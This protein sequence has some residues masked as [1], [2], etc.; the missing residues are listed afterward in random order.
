MHTSNPWFGRGGYA[1]QTIGAGIE[2]IATAT[3][4]T[5]A[6]YGFRGGFGFIVALC[7]IVGMDKVLKD[8]LNELKT[9]ENQLQEPDIERSLA[10]AKD[11]LQGLAMLRSFPQGVSIFGSARL[12]EDSKYYQSARKLGG[13][14]ANNGHP[15]V[16][17]GGHGIMAAASF[18]AYEYGGRVLGLNIKLPH[19]QTLNPYV[20]DS[21]EFHYFFARKVMLTMAAKAY[22]FYPGGFGTIDEFMEILVLMQTHKMPQMP[23]FLIDKKFWKPFEKF[24]ITRLESNGLISKK[25]R[26]FYKITDDITEVVEAANKI[27]HQKIGENI[28]DSDIYDNLKRVKK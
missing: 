3:G 12:P 25:D 2:R 15:V 24:I 7:Y 26:G 18:G 16:T 9:Q 22:V 21:I 27:G 5:T 13:L 10:Y 17:G 4:D 28:Y 23:M 11:L 20:S 8:W 19:E 14:L 6:S 1:E